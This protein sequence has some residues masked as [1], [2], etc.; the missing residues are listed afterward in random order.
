VLLE[1]KDRKES[2]VLKDRKVLLER[3]DRKESPVLKD[4]KD[5]VEPLVVVPV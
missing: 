4:R 2:P 5:P 3:R 1:R